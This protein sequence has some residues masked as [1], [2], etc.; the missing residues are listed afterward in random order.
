MCFAHERIHA[1]NSEIFAKSTAFQKFRSLHV[2]TSLFQYVCRSLF[3][4]V[5]LFCTTLTWAH[6]CRQQ[7]D[8][9][10]RRSFSSKVVVV[11]TW[12]T[13]K[14]LKYSIYKVKTL[15]TGILR[16][17]QTPKFLYKDT[18]QRNFEKFCRKGTAPRARQLP[19]ARDALPKF[20]KQQLDTQFTI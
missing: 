14:I 3:M 5:S 6:S 19:F 10:K 12:C 15:H 17:S 11:C 7:S 9:R 18:A 13:A 4:Y 8:P 2:H 20:S 16:N 1:A